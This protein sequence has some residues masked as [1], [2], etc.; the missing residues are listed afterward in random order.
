MPGVSPVL[1]SVCL[2]DAEASGNALRAAVLVERE[3]VP[4]AKARTYLRNKTERLTSSFSS[5][6]T[7]FDDRV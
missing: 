2:S 3:H 5:F 4:G 7:E 1:Y 6:V